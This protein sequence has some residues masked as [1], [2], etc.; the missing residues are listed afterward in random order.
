MCRRRG[1]SSRDDRAIILRQPNSQDRRIPAETVRRAD[2]IPRSL[3]PDGLLDN[4]P[5]ADVR[6]LFAYLKTLK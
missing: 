1:A 2:Y 3:M 4:M 6:D 5:E